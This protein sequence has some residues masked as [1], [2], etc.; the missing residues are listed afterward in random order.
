[1]LKTKMCLIALAGFAL[2]GTAVAQASD[3]GKFYKLDF[4]VREVEAGKTVN[5]RSY[6]TMLAIQT[7]G[8]KEVG[9]ATIRA[10][11]RVPVPSGNGTQ[12]Y[13]LGVNIDAR[14][15][16][17]SQTDVALYITTDINTIAQ[18]GGPQALPVTRSNRWAGTV[19]LPVKKP[20]VVFAS[21]D[22]ASKR[23]IQL[24]V[25]AIPVK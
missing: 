17:E 24:E 2:A 18:D 10:G 5:A 13:D 21:D 8:A 3:A 4:V 16:R 15:L 11:G 22:V 9:P 1:M 14:D 12:F 7:P 20:T 23:Q 19:L 6:A 25:T